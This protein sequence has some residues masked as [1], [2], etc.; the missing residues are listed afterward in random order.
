M[1]A[2]VGVV[3]AGMK[4]DFP[5]QRIYGRQTHNLTSIVT[6]SVVS[7]VSRYRRIDRYNTKIFLT[8]GIA[9]PP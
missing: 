2:M 4:E 9:G 3:E 1:V 6:S 5:F 7:D 8:V